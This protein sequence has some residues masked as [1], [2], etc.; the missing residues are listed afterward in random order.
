MIVADLDRMEVVVDVNENDVVSVN[1]LMFTDNDELAGLLA[2]M[3]ELPDVGRIA[4]PRDRRIAEVAYQV[5]ENTENIGA[6][7]LHTVMERLLEEISFD[8]PDK[9]GQHLVIDRDYVDSSL[10]ELVAD[11]DLSRYI[12]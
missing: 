5:N 3:G 2:G 8:A 9:A 6:R 12:L 1:E 7:R 4:D 11:E 10:G